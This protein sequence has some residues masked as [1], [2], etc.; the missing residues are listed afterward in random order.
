MKRITLLLGLSGILFGGCV[1][2]TLADCHNLCTRYADCFDSSTDVV[3]CTRRCESRVD[4]G[5]NDRAD[6]CDSCLNEYDTC[7][8]ATVACGVHCIPLLGP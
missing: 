1:L 3:D 8:G 5:E 2:D 6:R 7:L 4:S